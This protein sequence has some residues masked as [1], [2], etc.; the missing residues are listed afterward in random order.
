MP[1]FTSRLEMAVLVL[2]ISDGKNIYPK[3]GRMEVM[4]ARAP[5]LY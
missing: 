2:S 5:M 3:A 1:N 4:V